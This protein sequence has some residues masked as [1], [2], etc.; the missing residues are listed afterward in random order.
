M[1]VS[2]N[3]QLILEDNMFMCSYMIDERIMCE[4]CDNWDWCL[5][6]KLH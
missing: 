5:L 6:L 3:N 2:S 1:L 4:L